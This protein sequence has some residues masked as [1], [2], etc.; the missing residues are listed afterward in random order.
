M[1]NMPPKQLT[2]A[3]VTD[4]ANWRLRKTAGKPPAS[5]PGQST[6]VSAQ[7]IP[8]IRN[9]KKTPDLYQVVAIGRPKGQPTAT[10]PQETRAKLQKITDAVHGLEGFETSAPGIVFAISYSLLTPRQVGFFNSALEKYIEGI[11][12]HLKEPPV[13]ESD[14]VVQIRR[15]MIFGEDPGTTVI[16]ALIFEFRPVG[17]SITLQAYSATLGYH[18]A[19]YMP[20][21]NEAREI[22][23]FPFSL[24]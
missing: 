24:R 18:G 1:K 23:G 20:L 14:S 6:P 21:F 17:H 12:H 2:I 16:D 9:A 11:Q 3:T 19:L 15:A 7:V 13:E 5:K 22:C 8:L 10:L 4:L